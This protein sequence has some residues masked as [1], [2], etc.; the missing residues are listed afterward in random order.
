VIA[1]IAAHELVL[2]RIARLLVILAH[3]LHRGFDGFRSAAEGL[4]EVQVARCHL[5][6][7][8]DEVERHV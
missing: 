1:L 8:F 5:A 6:D 7:A 3:E 2:A 4:H